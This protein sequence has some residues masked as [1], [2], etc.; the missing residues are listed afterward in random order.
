MPPPTTY[1]RELADW[2]CEQL[3]KGRTL[4]DICGAPNMPS[5][6]TVQKWA[7]NDV[8]GFEERY[9]AAQRRR[10]PPIQYTPE[11][12]DRICQE[13]GRGRTVSDIC[14]DEGMPAQKTIWK[15]ANRDEEFGARYR[16]LRTQGSSLAYP[17]EVAEQI[18][19][20]LSKGRLLR[21]ICLDPGMPDI[22]TVQLWVRHDRDGFAERYKLAC[23]FGHR[24]MAEEIVSIA[25]DT[26]G[27]WTERPAADGGS[28][29]VFNS[30]NVARAR[31]RMDG[32]RWLLA[33]S[34]PQR[35]G[36]RVDVKATHDPGDK[37][38]QVLKA[39]D[40]RTR[41]ISND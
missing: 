13:L 27:D 7:R 5:E 1:T 21:E 23:E 19:A 35:Y 41:G 20:E 34:S 9:R 16:E 11:I 29:L 25:D 30:G 10:G 37:L 22:T 24:V 3:R 32:R 15:W 40:G 12:G 18:C 8:D 14:S 4:T 6:S 17:Q 33:K 26:R 2:I 36:D 28:T 39:I 31:L 38:M